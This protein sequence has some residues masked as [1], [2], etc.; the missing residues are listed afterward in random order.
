M[1]IFSDN[2][3]RRG[4]YL[5]LFPAILSLCAFAIVSCGGEK[6]DSQ[7]GKPAT[8]AWNQK[9]AV[10]EYRLIRA[11]IKLAESE[12]PYLVLDLA[13]QKV[14]LRLKG[15][16]VWEYPMELLGTDKGDLRDF[17]SDFLGEKEQFVRPI[18]EQYLFASQAQTPDSVLAIISEATNFDKSL[19]QRD[20]PSRFQLHWTGGL[21]L[22]VRTDVEGKET[23]SFKN[24][25]RDLQQTIARPFGQEIISCKM[26]KDNALTLYRTARPGVPTLLIPA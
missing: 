18:L 11:E 14:Q 6:T 13:H 4:R 26:P 2:R 17:G 22:D 7:E 1:S 8:Q 16:V 3:P 21:I 9:S 19:L 12:K 5:V 10:E 15:V 24:R 20:L 25:L 23:S